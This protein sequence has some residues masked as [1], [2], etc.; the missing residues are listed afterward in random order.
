MTHS[1]PTIA[2]EV[3]QWQAT[4]GRNHLPWQQTRD[5]Y[6]VWLSEIMLQQTQVTTVLGY[7]E[8]FL[9]QFPDVASLAAAP[10]DDVMALWSGLGYYTRA[11][12]LHRCAKAVVEQHGGAFPRSAALLAT[13]PG[14]GRSTAAAIASFCFGERAAILDANVKR[15]LTR[16]LAY[17]EDLSSTRNEKA[18]WAL[19]EAL[20]PTEDLARSMPRYTQGL[21][22][23]G[24]TVCL[25]RKPACL[26]CPL[27]A[28]CRAA[29]QGN[30]QDYPVKTRKTKRSSQ[31]WWLLVL[32]DTHGKL[33]LQRRPSSGGDTG[34]W[35]GLFS[36]PVFASAQALDEVLNASP[37][38]Q[39]ARTDW[40]AQLHVLTHRDLFLHPVVVDV[41]A[42]APALAATALADGGWYTAAQWP[43]L[44]LP[45]PIRKL[46]QAL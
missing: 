20:L 25:P 40:P 43:E 18:L 38:Q 14:I 12:N 9:A 16:V 46:L 15:V 8:R 6:R 11:R 31:A 39:T 41:E 45:A 33:W 34:I 2:T 4:H 27:Q 36:P 24:A 7:Y 19:A 42:Q 17:G 22:D 5:P 35:A 1:L 29:Q 3:V 32:R 10:E 23:L 13:L 28:Q 26:L 44:G 30:P 37:M 21:M